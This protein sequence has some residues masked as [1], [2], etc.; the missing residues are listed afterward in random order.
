M[1]FACA[2]TWQIQP[3]NKN[4]IT[5]YRILIQFIFEWLLFLFVLESVFF[6]L[7]A[8]LSVYERHVYCIHK[9][10]AHSSYFLFG[11]TRKMACSYSPRLWIYLRGNWNRKH[12]YNREWEKVQRKGERSEGSIKRIGRRF[13]G[14]ATAVRQSGCSAS[15]ALWRPKQASESKRNRAKTGRNG[16]KDWG[17][18]LGSKYW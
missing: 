2:R 13:W 16:R 18:K 5:C 4:Y 8:S 7:F 6:S 17:A 15:P 14:N 9:T 12:T 1:V 10:A 3:S 11:C